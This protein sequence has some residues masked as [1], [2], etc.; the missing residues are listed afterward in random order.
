MQT[1]RDAA[2]IFNFS[3]MESDSQHTL[4]SI[5]AV[6]PEQ[7]YCPS[8]TSQTE[9]P[10]ASL[11]RAVLEEALTCFQ[12]QFY[13]RHYEAQ[14]LGKEAEL[15]FFSDETDWPF[16]FVNICNVLHLEPAYIR[17]GLRNW[18]ANYPLKVPQRKR[19]TIGARRPLKLAA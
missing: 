15:W 6:M 16:A 10:E 2:H 17:R 5:A 14:R 1:H 7:F 11:M 8:F 18:Q 9:C 13:L 4:F 12:N 3:P 19:R